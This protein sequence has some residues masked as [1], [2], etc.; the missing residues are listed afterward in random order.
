MQPLGELVPILTTASRTERATLRAAREMAR[1]QAEHSRMAHLELNDG[2]AITK[3][4]LERLSACHKTDYPKVDWRSLAAREPVA[5]PTRTQAR[6]R[7]ARHALATWK[8]TWQERVFGD[9][10]QRRR[11]LAGRVLEASREDEAIFQQAYRQAQTHNAETF[12]ARK[13]LELD[14]KAIRDTIA[15]KTRLAEVRDGMNA[16]GLVLPGGGRIVGAAEAIP[17]VDIPHERI[18]DVDPRLARREVISLVGRRQIHLAALCAVG[19]RVGAELVSVLPL[20]AVEVVVS[21][22]L[23]DAAGGRATLQP[24]LQLLMT[25]KALARPDWKTSDSIT[26]ATALGARM[27]WSIEKGFEPIRVIPLSAMGRSLAE[28]A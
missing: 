5:L 21:C 12:L 1:R 24:V 11:Q 23:P 15:L 16:V 4:E 14:P 19:L 6:E 22:E 26:L 27:D 8:P 18:T 7:A 17:E 25:R 13:L 2:L 20:E 28:T 3:P 10:A 9:E